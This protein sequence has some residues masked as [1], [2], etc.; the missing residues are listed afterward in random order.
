MIKTP[1]FFKKRR[2][3]WKIHK[4]KRSVKYAK[5]AQSLI[6]KL[7]LD[8]SRLHWWHNSV[9][10]KTVKAVTAV[11]AR[12]NDRK[13]GWRLKWVDFRKEIEKKCAVFSKLGRLKSPQSPRFH[14]ARVIQS[15]NVLYK[16]NFYPRSASYGMECQN[17]WWYSRLQKG[18][19]RQKEKIQGTFP[20]IFSF[21]LTSCI[22]TESHAKKKKVTRHVW[23]S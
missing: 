8:Q 14:W 19:P 18:R 17:N 11:Q 1:L 22:K 2:V 23:P 16:K 20:F 6:N 3:V 4:L 9:H 13:R 7:L 12:W 21:F 10:L 15:D 5:S